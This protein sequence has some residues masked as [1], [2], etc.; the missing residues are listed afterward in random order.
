MYVCM[1][2][3]MFLQGGVLISVDELS[4]HMCVCKNVCMY[5][6]VYV[7]MHVC[8]FLQ[9]DVLFSVDE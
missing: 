6:C 5:V 8:M 3:C 7:C 2:V 1:H 9:G 4:S